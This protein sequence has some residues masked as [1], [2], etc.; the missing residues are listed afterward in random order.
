[1]S[2]VFTTQKKTSKKKVIRKTTLKRVTKKSPRV[3]PRFPS[4]DEKI[5]ILY[6]DPDLLAVDKPAGLIVQG[7]QD[8]KTSLLH[9]LKSQYPGLSPLHRLDRNVTGAVIFAKT[10]KGASAMSKLMVA[11]GVDKTYLAIV[12]GKPPQTG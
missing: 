10:K 1:M 7:A 12:W 6:E 4:G 3:F 9:R 8:K 5:K 11:G 2:P